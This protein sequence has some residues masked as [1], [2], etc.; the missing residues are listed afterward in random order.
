MNRIKRKLILGALLLSL[1]CIFYLYEATPVTIIKEKTPI[2]LTKD[3]GILWDT[4]ESTK[5]I[6]TEFT[7]EEVRKTF[8]SQNNILHAYKGWK[9]I[10]APYSSAYTKD[11]YSEFILDLEFRW[12]DGKF[13][14]R[15][16]KPKDAGIIFHVFGG[17]NK[18]WPSGIEYQLKEPE[19]YGALV[20]VRTR[21]LV[22]YEDK[23]YDKNAK[24]KVLGKNKGAAHLIIKPQK[25]INTEWNKL[26]LEVNRDSGTFY[27][28][29]EKVM[30]YRKAE[31]FNKFLRF[32][33]PLVKGRIIL[34]AEG[35]EVEYR[36]IT[37][38]PISS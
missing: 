30:E 7:H 35:A 5:R 18:P 9:N 26:R 19:Q 33:S 3:K 36:N 17:T 2:F 14:P 15:A 23:L 12:G 22:T 4:S 25:P 34:Q 31:K 8:T 37:L 16:S 32:W 10:D 13:N 6:K 27:L 38:S 1:V 20:T 11:I 28:N 21:A 29:D 24:E